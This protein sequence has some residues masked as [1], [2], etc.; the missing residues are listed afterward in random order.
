MD[1]TALLSRKSAR[2]PDTRSL[3]DSYDAKVLDSY[4]KSGG[5]ARI[6]R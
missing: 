4:S 3:P 6:W 1:E 2:Y 5:L